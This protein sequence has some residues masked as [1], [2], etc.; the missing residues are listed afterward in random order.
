LHEAR[1]EDI[2]AVIGGGAVVRRRPSAFRSSSPIVE[3]DARFDD[4]RM[5]T[6]VVKDLGRSSQV[7]RVRRAKPAFLYDPLR[8]IVT[9]RNV[10]AGAGLGTAELHGFLVEPHKDRYLLA[11]E[12]V[13]GVELYQV[14]EIE[15]WQEALRWL[16]RL[17]DRFRG[18]DLP[19]RL[20]RYDPAY[21]QRWRGRARQF[22]G[23]DAPGYNDLVQR[24]TSLPPTLL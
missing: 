19:A 16:A 15:V 1:D 12:K 5:A 14:G 24:L 22:D 21:F 18:R 11:L 2:T 7:E 8:E 23:F 3:V 9:Y 10:L 4:G 13:E 17:H 20:I 6:V